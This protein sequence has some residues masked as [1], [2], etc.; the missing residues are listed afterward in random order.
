MSECIA[1]RIQEYCHNF[2]GYRYFRMS[3]QFKDM[4]GINDLGIVSHTRHTHTQFAQWV[5]KQSTENWYIYEQNAL[6]STSW[7]KHVLFNNIRFA[8][9]AVTIY[10]EFWI[11]YSRTII[12]NT[13][14]LTTPR[15]S[16]VERQS[17]A[18]V[19]SSSCALPVADGWPL[20]WVSRP[21]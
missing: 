8:T 20:M 2:Q 5:T 1:V 19:L 4:R 11:R 18:S 10:I 15:G 14:Q 17:L 12:W 13:G 7:Q 3:K 6:N 9:G 16:A 21:I